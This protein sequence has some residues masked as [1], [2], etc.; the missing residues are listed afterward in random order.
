V[1]R[2]LIY[3]VGGILIALSLI[4]IG[5]QSRQPSRASAPP[6][7]TA[8]AADTLYT[9][10]QE[11][12]KEDKSQAKAVYQDILQNHN[13]YAEMDAVQKNLEQLKLDEIFSGSEVPGK[14]AFHEVESGDTLIKIAQKYGTTVDLLKRN[15]NL[16]S[17]VIRL[18]QR[19]RVWT[20]SFNI[21][22]D[23]SQ[24][25]LMLKDGNDV[26]K[27]YQV[28]TGTNNSTPVGNFKI[29]SKLTDP[30][31][32]H[33]GA[34]VPP[35]SPENELGTRWLGFDISGYGIH[36]TIKPESIGQQVTAGCVR[37]RNREV[38]ELYSLIPM[39]T[40]VTVVD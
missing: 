21:L 25:I 8:Q 14:T 36:G 4:K 19:L 5:L 31:W 3:V 7:D 6:R 17:D 12:E 24:N 32:F 34:V 26:V 11:L 27:V 28:S 9:R 29:V 23:K 37:M 2:K 22:V 20:G 16:Q 39:G 30:V 13:D 18:G 35:E 33:K 1:N 15:N 10:A 40:A 38:E